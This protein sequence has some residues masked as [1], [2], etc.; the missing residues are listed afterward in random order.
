MGYFI[1]FYPDWIVT[2]F[3]DPVFF[4]CP[5]YYQYSCETGPEK[6]Q[7]REGQP[8]SP[9]SYKTVLLPAFSDSK[10]L[11]GSKGESE[12]NQQSEAREE[13]GYYGGYEQKGDPYPQEALY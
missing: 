2:I 3:I 6:P 12:G 10:G 1:I 4:P 5:V 9:S 13:V 11:S 8:Y 7:G